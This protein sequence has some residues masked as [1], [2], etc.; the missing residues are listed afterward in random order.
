MSKFYVVWVGKVPGV[1]NSWSETQEQVS[2]FPKAKYKSF[3]NKADAYSAFTQ[4]APEYPTRKTKT[5]KQEE[6]KKEHLNTL[7]EDMDIHIYCDGGCEPNPGNAGSG[8]VVYENKEVKSLFYGLYN[9]M[10][11]NNTAELNALTEAL[12]VA[13]HHIN[14]N[15][16]VQILCDSMYSINCITKWA[17]GWSEA[18]WLKSD[19]VIKNVDLIKQAYTIYEPIQSKI[20]ISHIKGHAGF[21]G[22]ELADRMSILAIT[23]KEEGFTSLPTPF[24]IT[25]LLDFK[26]G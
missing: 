10:G 14:Q 9:P 2:G 26:R 22:N 18:L 12:R 25:Q 23:N 24:D 21:E 3:E 8:V 4:P 19:G 17:K 1:Y 6:E 15:K 20:T 11:T 5:Q 7:I 16:K 13:T